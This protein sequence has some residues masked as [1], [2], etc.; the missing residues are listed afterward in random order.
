[1]Y[2]VLCI[3]W[4]ILMA[5]GPE[6][7]VILSYLILSYL[8]SYLILSYNIL[9]NSLATPSVVMVMSDIGGMFVLG[10]CGK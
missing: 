4:C 2:C 8:I 7:N 3:L 5:S 6:I 9:S 10:S 1:M